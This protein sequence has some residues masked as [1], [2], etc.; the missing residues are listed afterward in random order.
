Y[1]VSA[2]AMASLSHGGPPRTLPDG[3]VISSGD[4]APA[5]ALR[6]AKEGGKAGGKNIVAGPPDEAYG[7]KGDFN[8]LRFMARQN[9]QYV[10]A[11]AEYRTLEPRLATLETHTA[12]DFSEKDNLSFQNQARSFELQNFTKF[13]NF[14]ALYTGIHLRPAHFDDREVG[15]GAALQ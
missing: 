6:A 2:Q 7:K 8:D 3:T 12:I 9:L 15:D 5:V 4:A 13:N 11:A 14:W 10:H 1:V